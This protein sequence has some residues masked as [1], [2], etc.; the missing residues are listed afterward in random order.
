[1]AQKKPTPTKEAPA[2]RGRRPRRGIVRRGRPRGTGRATPKQ[3]F[4]LILDPDEL[5][6]LK[7]MARGQRTS[8]AAIIRQALHTVIFR[9]NPELAKTAIE[10][11]VNSFLDHMGSKLP[12]GSGGPKRARLKK[13]MVTGLLSGMKTR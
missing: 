13:Q 6:A 3:P 4:S 9:T 7:K 1:M 11:E 12:I 2:P 8:V 10:N 5:T